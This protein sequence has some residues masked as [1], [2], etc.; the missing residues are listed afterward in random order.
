MTGKV[1]SKGKRQR[2]HQV[3]VQHDGIYVKINTEQSTNEK[4][5]SDFYVYI[6]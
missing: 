5:P 6:I 3:K 4:L 2:V 1:T